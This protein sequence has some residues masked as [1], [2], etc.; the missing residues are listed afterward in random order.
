MRL[1]YLIPELIPHLTAD[2]LND[3]A[4][5]LCPCLFIQGKLFLLR[6]GFKCQLFHVGT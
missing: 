5:D 1:R 4:F 6:H 2:P 3:C